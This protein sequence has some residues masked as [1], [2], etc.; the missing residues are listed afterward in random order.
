MSKFT[1][2]KAEITA[3]PPILTATGRIAS[4]DTMQTISGNPSV[5]GNFSKYGLS[6]PHIS[7]SSKVEIGFRLNCTPTIGKDS[8][9]IDLSAE[10]KMHVLRGFE[11]TLLTGSRAKEVR[12]SSKE[13]TA[14]DFPRIRTPIFDSNEVKTEVSLY[15]GQTV[16]FD[17]GGSRLPSAKLHEYLFLTARIVPTS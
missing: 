3:F 9:T 8:C 2:H 14:D 6:R 15:D 7:P 13:W 4:I 5:T 10:L 1:K 16:V 17:L 12:H 11:E